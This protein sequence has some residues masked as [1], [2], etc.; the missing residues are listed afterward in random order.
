MRGK[1]TAVSETK[2]NH[3]NHIQMVNNH[4]IECILK[5]AKGGHD[6]SHWRLFWQGFHFV[7]HVLVVFL[8]QCHF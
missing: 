7:V 5:A 1:G 4:N 3:S 6:S 8:E 2:P